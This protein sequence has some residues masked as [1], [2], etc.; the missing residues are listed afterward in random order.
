MTTQHE[1]KPGSDADFEHLYSVTYPNLLRSL[2]LM[3]G[4][5]AE[6]EDCVQDAYARAY[7]AW[8]RWRPD[9]PAEAW[10]WRITM[11][12]ANTRMVQGKRWRIGEILRR[13]GK[14]EVGPDP[15]NVVMNADLKDAL[16]RLRPKERSA[17][18]LRHLHG[19]SNIDI[20]SYL[21]VDV[22]TVTRLLTKG[23]ERLRADLGESWTTVP[24]SATV[25]REGLS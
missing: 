2:G 14:P 16:A 3:L 1:Y 22:R 19:H 11:N 21:G 18:V 9:A 23:V 4:N 5:W 15:S 7:R 12:V 25:S 8:P 10:L 20:A 17:V 6:A 24:A 13:F